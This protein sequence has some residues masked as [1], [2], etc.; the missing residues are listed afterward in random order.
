[1]PGIFKGNEVEKNTSIY[2]NWDNSFLAVTKIRFIGDDDR[3]NQMLMHRLSGSDIFLKHKTCVLY[4]NSTSFF[5]Q[6]NSNKHTFSSVSSM[7]SSLSF[8]PLWRML[9]QDA[10]SSSALDLPAT[11]LLQNTSKASFRACWTKE[12]GSSDK[13]DRTRFKHTIFSNTNLVKQTVVWEQIFHLC[14]VLVKKLVYF[15]DKDLKT[16]QQ[17]QTP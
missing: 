5:Y 13:K 8:P 17:H 7:S 2:W 1:M 6:E 16:T 11:A 12:K 14:H 10:A 3:L 9:S 15:S 4:S